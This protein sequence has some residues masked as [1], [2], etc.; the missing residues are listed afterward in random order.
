MIGDATELTAV[1]V[2][3]VIPTVI[4]IVSI[5][6]VDWLPIGIDTA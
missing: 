1:N 3:V 6:V 4:E 2:T 5:A